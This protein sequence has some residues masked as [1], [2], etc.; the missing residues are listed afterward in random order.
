MNRKIILFII[1]ALFMSFIP[2][3]ASGIENTMALHIGSPLILSEGKMKPLDSNNP[4]VVPIIHK[5]RTL[6][7]LRAISEHFGAE[8]NYDAAKMEAI[9]KYMG[10]T[11][12]FPIGKNTVRISEP[13]KKDSLLTY[14]TEALIMEDRT[15]VPLRLIA[16]E[17]LKK[18]VGYRDN[19]ITIGKSNIDDDTLDNIR[20]RIGQAIRPHS[21]NELLGSLPVNKDLSF[22]RQ[23]IADIKQPI[24]AM[25]ATELDFR[26]ES[27]E[28]AKGLDD[29]SQTNEQ[30]EG[31]NES[32][33]VK[34]D[35]KFIYI[36]SGKSIKIY[37]SNNGRP[38]LTDEIAIK[39]DS[40]TGEII[41][42]NELYVHNGKLIVLGIKNT[43]N[44]W[45][46]PLPD[47]P[48][49]GGI[50][51]Y[52][53]DKNYVY[54]AVY[55]VSPQGK[56]KLDRELELEGNL[57]SSRK[58]DENLYLIVNKYVYNYG[59]IGEPVFPLIRDSA[60]G[61]A[62]TELPLDKI[63]YFPRRPSE[64]Y[65]V[66]AALNVEK[67]EEPA[68]IEALLGA[69]NMVYM[70]QNA[71]YITAQDY[72]TIWGTITNIAKFN[73]NGTKFGFAGGG[74]VSGS[75]L[76]QFSM[77]EYEGN[78]RVA[79]TSQQRQS[80]NSIYILDKDLN[81]KGKIENLAP[82][83]RIYSARFMKDYGYIVTFRQIDPLFVLNLSDP[84]NPKVTGELK[85]P[86]FS[87]YLHP[88]TDKMLLGI[89][90]DVD[91]ETGFQKGIKLSMFDVSDEGKPK[92][93][94]TLILGSAGSYAEVLDNHKALMLNLK[95]DMIAFDVSL[96]EETDKFV[97]KSFNGAAVIETKPDGKLEVLKLISN[98]G[99]YG[100]YAKRI[101]Y[102]GENL[103]Y[104]LDDTIRVFDM[105]SFTEIE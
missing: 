103:Y 58:K 81:E 9:V 20:T 51:P 99:I 1:I 56:L 80:T 32:D 74:M 94:N 93:I 71:L 21:K 77:D 22:V 96:R 75:L 7:P 62:M 29:F 64:N 12:Y 87:S 37:D 28:I 43:L 97:Q 61:S 23:P 86:G 57:L 105:N 17:I 31:V 65:L 98:D 59:V 39:P 104:I 36:A 16:E 44:N 92:E 47:E 90:R 42:L 25:P 27:Q 67:P 30:V 5:D 89:G 41:Q 68:N 8:V 85:V 6:V 45:I 70:S 73:I 76:N 3:Y 52:Y 46:R 49:K 38:K 53:S 10:K 11:Y 101:I 26:V 83:E 84:S 4:N 54:A 79:T 13:D 24:A 15:M 69:G 50:L 18:Q 19:A 82:G 66:I 63:M 91:E 48:I 34:T 33:I 35:G 72:A 55:S 40:K 2:D 14:D 60:K 102:I 95:D 88:I 100:T 78:L